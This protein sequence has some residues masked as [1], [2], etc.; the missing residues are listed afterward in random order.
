MQ[1]INDRRVSGHGAFGYAASELPDRR[2]RLF[3]N[4]IRDEHYQRSISCTQSRHVRNQAVKM[5]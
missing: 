4:R 1:T 2:H 5:D 3:P